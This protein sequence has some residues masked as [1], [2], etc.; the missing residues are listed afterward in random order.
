MSNSRVIK[1]ISLRYKTAASWCYEKL[2]E[3]FPSEITR[4]HID[5][6]TA[7]TWPDPAL[8]DGGWAAELSDFLPFCSFSAVVFVTIY[9]SSPSL[10]CF[11]PSLFELFFNH[12][13]RIWNPTAATL[14]KYCF[15]PPLFLSVST[16]SSPGFPNAPSLPRPL[17]VVF[18]SWICLH[19]LMVLV[20][21][22]WN[23]S[24]SQWEASVNFLHTPSFHQPFHS[25]W[26]GF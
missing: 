26:D 20:Q 15:P 13:F 19:Q 12:F 1:K 10:I 21:R 18:R 11:F 23:S 4:C 2:Q 9:L 17:S 6:Y 8:T 16:S 14:Q 5:V 3:W 25:S 24:V 7:G 22:E